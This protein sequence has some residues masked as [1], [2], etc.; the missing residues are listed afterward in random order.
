MIGQIIVK[1]TKRE[2]TFILGE[3]WKTINK[4]DAVLV[5]EVRELIAEYNNTRS[6]EERDKIKEKLIS[7]CA[8]GKKIENKSDLKLIFDILLDGYECDSNS[9]R[10]IDSCIRRLI[11]DLLFWDTV[12]SHSNCKVDRATINEFLNELGSIEI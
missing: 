9:D 10:E 7:I 12:T 4:V 2:L 1:E 8:P 11:F 6:V 5:E 3:S